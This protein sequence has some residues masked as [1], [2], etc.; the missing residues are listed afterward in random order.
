MSLSYFEMR[1]DARCFI[2]GLDVSTSFFFFLFFLSVFH[3]ALSI[4]LLPLCPSDFIFYSHV[5]YLG[6]TRA[7]GMELVMDMG[8]GYG[9]FC[10]EIPFFFSV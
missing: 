8:N 1:Y 9:Y 3:F 4:N 10:Y 2:C 5:Y 7:I 6:K